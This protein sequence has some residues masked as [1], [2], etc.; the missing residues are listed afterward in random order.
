MAFIKEHIKKIA[1]YTFTESDLLIIK[2]LMYTR[3]FIPEVINPSMS[4][5]V[6]NVTPEDLHQA[7]LRFK[8]L[9]VKYEKEEPARIAREEKI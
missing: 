1:G 9:I 2:S 4:N 6:F 3:L 7:A 5:E 8:R